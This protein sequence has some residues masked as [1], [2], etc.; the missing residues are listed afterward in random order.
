MRI[1]HLCSCLALGTT[2]CELAA[3]DLLGC[4]YSV[5]QA[6]F[7][8]FRYQPYRLYFLVKDDTAGR[9]RLAEL[10]QDASILLLTDA[11]V[12]AEVVGLD[13]DPGHAVTSHVADLQP[14][15]FPAAVL[16]S[17]GDKAVKLPWPGTESISERSVP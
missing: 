6:G 1:V 4:P 3:T 10:V 2:I 16:V 15:T 13:E 9:E 8:P 17:P 7:I 14:L 11:N 5:R 12:E